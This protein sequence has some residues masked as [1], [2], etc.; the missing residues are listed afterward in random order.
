[1]KFKL[2]AVLFFTSYLAQAIEGFQPSSNRNVV[3]LKASRS[4]GTAFI[5]DHS[6]HGKILITQ[7]HVL[8]LSP[9]SLNLQWG[10]EVGPFFRLNK[11]EESAYQ[12]EFTPQVI[13]QD[14]DLDVAVLKI[15]EGLLE[16]CVCT[17]LKQG[18]FSEGSATLIGY[19][20]VQRRIWPQTS[21]WVWM[22]REL[23]GRV[24][25][26]VSTGKVWKSG[27][28]YLGDIDSIS[29]NSG[30]PIIQ[31]D[32]VI[33]IIHLLKTWKGEGYR[34]KNPSL[35]FI[36]IETIIAALSVKTKS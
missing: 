4:G 30:G 22:W 17:G 16:K 21:N 6:V 13:W 1:M 31:E 33:G 25:Q 20:I 19:P 29:G 28:E 34:Y 36:P 5:F 2:F 10:H 7:K 15:P 3:M 14:N 24:Q 35:N 26:Q 23:W 32:K 8:E 11:M 27:D 12:I 9:D 18:S